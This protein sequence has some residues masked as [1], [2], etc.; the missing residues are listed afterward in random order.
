MVLLL[1]E[2]VLLLALSPYAVCRAG[3]PL[4]LPHPKVLFAMELSSNPEELSPG[5]G[6]TYSG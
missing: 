6:Y 3:T 5:G 2:M 4:P 1:A